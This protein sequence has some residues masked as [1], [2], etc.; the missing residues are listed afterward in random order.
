MQISIQDSI[1]FSTLFEKSLFYFMEF[2]IFEQV[3][4]IF[5]VVLQLVF[6]IIVPS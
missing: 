5:C 6:F 4:S 1:P 2:Y 3:A